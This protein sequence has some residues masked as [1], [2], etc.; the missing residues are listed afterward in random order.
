MFFD[1]DKVRQL[2]VLLVMFSVSQ[3]PMCSYASEIDSV[4]SVK[5]RWLAS[6]EIARKIEEITETKLAITKSDAKE[7]NTRGF[8]KYLIKG[9]LVVADLLEVAF[10]VNQDSSA[11]QGSSQGGIVID[12]R[13]EELIITNDESLG[14]GRIM[15]V[16]GEGVRIFGPE[17]A[18][19]LKLL[20]DTQSGS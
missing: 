20:L 4:K 13:K 8:S 16:T 10:L 6:E 3:F 19:E 5:V 12:T 11:N 9:V 14:V 7:D 1:L 17:D 15:V 2:I 18:P